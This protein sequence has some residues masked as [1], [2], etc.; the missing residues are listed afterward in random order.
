MKWLI[1]EI[2]I[3]YETKICDNEH[4]E[5]EFQCLCVVSLGD[6]RI[7]YYSSLIITRKYLP[8]IVVKKNSNKIQIKQQKKEG[9]EGFLF[10]FNCVGKLQNK[11]KEN[12]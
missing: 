6:G 5:K 11:G 7:N 12:K 1:Q 3:Y 10:F 8:F 2:F 4:I 9:N